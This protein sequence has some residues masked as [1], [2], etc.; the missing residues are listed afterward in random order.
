[1]VAT[2]QQHMAKIQIKI[3][4]M[5]YFFS[6]T[7]G[8]ECGCMN[9]ESTQDVRELYCWSERHKLLGRPILFISNRK[10]LWVHCVYNLDMKPFAS[11]DTPTIQ[12]TTTV[13]HTSFKIAHMK[14][15][16]WYKM[17]INLKNNIVFSCI[18]CAVM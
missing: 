16:V 3:F 9:F 12:I 1:M 15:E 5:H 13:V 8:L 18:L 4:K 11:L 2:T 6:T 14:R 17:I 10:Q 7:V